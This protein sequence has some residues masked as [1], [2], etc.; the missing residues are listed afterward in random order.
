[1]RPLI[2]VLGW[3]AIV[4]CCAALC[5]ASAGHADVIILKNGRRITAVNVKEAGDK[6]S[7]ETPAGTISLPASMVDHVERNSAEADS[8]PAATL[9]W[10]QPAGAG[11]ADA[12]RAD[13][14]D[15]AQ[16]QR[17]R[18]EAA[19]GDAAA[20]A[21]A[22][23]VESATGALEFAR[24]NLDEA[25][26]HAQ[27]ALAYDAT[28]TPRL[29]DVAYFQ[30]RLG[31]YGSAL[32]SLQRARKTAPESADVAKLTGWAYYGLNRLA[33]AVEEWTRSQ[34][35]HPDDDVAAAL[36]KA[37]RD[38]QAERE[39]REDGSEHFVLKYDGAS[40]PELAHGIL[41]E[42]EGDFQ[43]VSATLNYSPSE[44]IGVLLYT[45]QAFA[46]I[47]HARSWVGA[48]NDGRIRIPVQGL[49]AVT[50][51]L[52]QELRHELTHSLVGGKTRG[53]SPVWLQEGIA[54]WID[55]TQITPA[56]AAKLLSMYDRHED[57]S[58]T[59]L[60][61]SWMKFDSDL[62]SNAYAWSLAIVESLAHAGGPS[63]IEH[64]LERVATDASTEAAVRS[65]LG[66]DYA[67]L[68]RFA[69]DYLRR[70]YAR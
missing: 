26:V 54:Q 43:S 51:Q 42:L 7:G 35:I 45:T 31:E 13:A 18:R 66:F 65:S 59:L 68:S 20:V 17:L 41:R 70:H 67:G 38:L 5:F 11:E 24:G 30:L 2:R 63:D 25:L 36:A 52:A 34:K 40:A 61:G 32:E 8:S 6:I 9:R 53:R 62:A 46:D 55:G 37:E 15:P 57:P 58:L 33:P 47:T 4:A 39:F 10:S 23:A 14:V 50:P 69:A 22:A 44:R 1:M 27:R 56:G 29:L 64:L 60:E 16:L 21:R 28:S 12:E 19:G 48:L 3:P 49:A